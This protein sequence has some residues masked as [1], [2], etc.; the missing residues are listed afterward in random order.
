MPP[1]SRDE[2]RS[3]LCERMGWDGSD[4]VVRTVADLLHQRSSGNPLSLFYNIA[5]AESLGREPEEVGEALGAARLF[6]DTPHA[7]YD[8]LLDDIGEAARERGHRSLHRDV[9]SF[10]AVASTDIT[11]K[12][13]RVAFRDDQ[14]SS[15]DAREQLE[16]LRPIV[17]EQETGHYWLFHDDFRRF[18]EERLAAEDAK[19]AHRRHCAALHEDWSGSE[20]A[21]FAEHLFLGEEWSR[22]A[23]L[24]S[25][26]ALED[27]FCSAPADSVLVLHRLAIAAAFCQLEEISIIR[28]ALA[29]ARAVEATEHPADD[30]STASGE[31]LTRWTF[32]VPPRD[33]ALSTRAAAFDV[34]TRGCREDLALATEIVD[35]FKFP[36]DQVVDEDNPAWHEVEEYSRALVGW[37]LNSGNLAE[38]RRFLSDSALSPYGAHA[39]SAVFLAEKDPA[40]VQVWTQAL[41]GINEEADAAICEAA[42]R[43]LGDG[44]DR[45]ALSVATA[46]FNHGACGADAER[47]AAALVALIEGEQC[48]LPHHVDAGVRWDDRG[49]LDPLNWRGFFFCGF[50]AATV[51]P[52]RDV[53]TV[54]FP[55]RFDKF[56][57]RAQEWEFRVAS[58]IWRVGFGLGLANRDPKLLTE[59][60]VRDLVTP[61]LADNALGP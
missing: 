38:A 22:L 56:R 31:D 29:T 3:Y 46:M 1:F 59:R 15:R 37:F 10:L 47:D 52:V 17:V 4:E 57:D 27:W 43:H 48:V 61:L 39:L 44:R 40:V 36:E 54:E 13:F 21:A 12:R 5:I 30:V 25:T 42:C 53:R 9:M 35:R 8:Q 45:V 26:R 2:T 51:G 6:G 19:V 33:R 28:N 23:Q 32:R 49:S 60:D 11:E 20:L 34:A 18:A 55:Q 41:A 14:L 7:E 50:A 16:L 58:Y 24:P